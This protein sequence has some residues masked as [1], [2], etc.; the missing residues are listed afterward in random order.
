MGNINKYQTLII[1]LAVL[2]GLVIGQNVL[3]QNIASHLIVP[4]LMIML[5]GLF[6]AMPVADFKK[7]IFNQ[8]FIALATMVNFVFIP[9]LA[10]GLGSLF[11]SHNIAL[12][13]GFVM[14]MVTPCTDW[15]I[16]FT[17]IAKGNV[18]LAISIL[19]INLLIQ[20]ILLPVY[21]FLFFNQS[22]I[23]PLNA[24][25]KSIVLMILVPFFVAYLTRRIIRLK[26]KMSFFKETIIPKLDLVQI[27]FLSLAIIAMFASEGQHLMAN[28]QIVYE[29]L[30]PLL[31]FFTIIFV[32]GQLLGR[33]FGLNYAD[34]VSLTLTTLARNSPIA[35]AIAIVA[36]PDTPIIA[37]ALIVGPLIELP[38]LILVSQGLLWTR[39][40]Q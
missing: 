33:W 7:N 34:K 1:L 28:S 22:T 35:L 11:L 21:I 15:Y 25:L 10:Y 20:V 8:R 13:M 40:F 30:P 5:Y 17:V 19:P 38:V 36:F 14:L 23:L 18:P 9:L 26:D 6:L 39:K 24:L 31:V 16:V 27:L 12:W 29:L 32:V 37:L 3:I 4:F 2:I